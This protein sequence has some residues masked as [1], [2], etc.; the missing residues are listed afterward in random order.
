MVHDELFR[1]SGGARPGCTRSNDMVKTVRPGSRPG[2]NLD[3][4]RKSESKPTEITEI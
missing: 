4:Q 3:V 1:F 2:E